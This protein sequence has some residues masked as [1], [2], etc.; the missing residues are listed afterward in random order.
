MA[1]HLRRLPGAGYPSF[2]DN[3]LDVLRV[4]HSSPTGRCLPEPRDGAARACTVRDS[5]DYFLAFFNVE[6]LLRNEPIL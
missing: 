2:A 5:H 4:V 1:F 6:P 3:P